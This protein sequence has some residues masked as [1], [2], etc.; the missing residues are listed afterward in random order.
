[1]FLLCSPSGSKKRASLSSSS[2]SLSSY[3]VGGVGP[4]RDADPELLVERQEVLGHELGELFVCFGRGVLLLSRFRGFEFFFWVFGLDSS[5]RLSPRFIS[6]K[7]ETQSVTSLG[8][9]Q[10][11][12][13]SMSASLA[14]VSLRE[15]SNEEEVESGEDEAAEAMTTP[16]GV[17]MR[18]QQRRRRRCCARAAG[19]TGGTTALVLLAALLLLAIEHIAA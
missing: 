3:L 16:T 12:S 5:R 13:W 17:E 7:T 8:P 15:D 6:S 19:A 1:M 14:C 18:E 10:A 9:L 4:G 11:R 2:S